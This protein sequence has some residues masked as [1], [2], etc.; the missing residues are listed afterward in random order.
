M[1]K[2]RLVYEKMSVFRRKYFIIKLLFNIRR[3]VKKN[4]VEF[5]MI[6]WIRENVS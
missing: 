2:V 1:K 3:L 4:L 5:N 6:F